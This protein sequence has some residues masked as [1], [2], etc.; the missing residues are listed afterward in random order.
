[1]GWNGPWL[2]AAT[3]LL[4]SVGA[5]TLV[6]A[7]RYGK[8]IVV[9]PLTNAGAPLVTALIA[10]AL[11]G[12]VPQPLKT[13]GIVLA[14]VAAA[15]LA[16]EPEE[17][18]MKAL[19]DLVRRHRAGE[20]VG[21]YSVCSA[22]PLVL[23]AA[24]EHAGASGGLCPDRGHLEPGEP[25]GRLHRPAAGAVSGSGVRHGGRGGAGA[26][27]CAPGGRSPGSE[28]LAVARVRRKRC[29]APA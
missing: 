18:R 1:M 26:R 29:G 24:L 28:R 20:A 22:H 10:L 13:A 21:I 11:L 12:L 25:G 17:E 2:A 14:F 23:R 27:A 6:Y 7:F 19:L 16:I 5:L 3:Q 8:A 4:N 9:S 15:L